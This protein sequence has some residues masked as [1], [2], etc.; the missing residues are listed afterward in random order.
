MFERHDF[1]SATW[2]RSNLAGISQMCMILQD[3]GLIQRIVGQIGVIVMPV[4][5]QCFHLK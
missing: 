3:G 4:H 2:L 5:I 1:D